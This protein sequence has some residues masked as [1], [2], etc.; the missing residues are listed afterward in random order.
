MRLQDRCHALALHPG[1]LATKLHA[2]MNAAA[3]WRANAKKALQGTEAFATLFPDDIPEQD[4]DATPTPANA[5]DGADDGAGAGPDDVDM[6]AGDADTPAAAV[7]APSA[8]APAATATAD[9]SPPLRKV[10]LSVLKELLSSASVLEVVPDEERA[11]ARMVTDVEVRG[12]CPHC[13]CVA[14]STARRLR[15]HTQCTD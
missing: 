5:A 10:A 4:A 13:A 9:A 11:L 14:T 2:M 15:A 6:T 7:P 12:P 8:T 1:P 3:D